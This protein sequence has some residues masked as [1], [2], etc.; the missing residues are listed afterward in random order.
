[1]EEVQVEDVNVVAGSHRCLGSFHRYLD[2]PVYV[3]VNKWP[4]GKAVN[5][6][7]WKPR[8]QPEPPSGA[9]NPGLFGLTSDSRS[10][11]KS[12]THRKRSL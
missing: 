10:E 8:A 1:M 6:G 3:W 4:T 12:C 11:Q 5:N 2:V 9:R 7:T